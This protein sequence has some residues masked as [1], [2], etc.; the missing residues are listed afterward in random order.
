MSLIEKYIR[1]HS[2]RINAA[3]SEANASPLSRRLP[4]CPA[5]GSFAIYRKNGTGEPECLTCGPYAQQ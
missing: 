1:K 4:S 5:C 3:P 2:A